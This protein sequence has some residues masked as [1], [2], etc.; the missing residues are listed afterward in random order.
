M[1][2]KKRALVLDEFFSRIPCSENSLHLFIT[3]LYSNGLLCIT[4]KTILS[5]FRGLEIRTRSRTRGAAFPNGNLRTGF[6]QDHHSLVSTRTDK[7]RKTYWLTTFM[8]T[9]N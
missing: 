1:A 3:N 8:Y 4:D 6:T 5:V 2:V 9:D 7:F